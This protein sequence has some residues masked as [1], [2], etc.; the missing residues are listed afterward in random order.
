MIRQTC[1]ELVLVSETDVIF[2]V[3]D[4]KNPS[5]VI[6]LT[7]SR[8]RHYEL[9]IFCHLRRI[10]SKPTQIHNLYRFYL[11]MR[12][13]INNYNESSNEVYLRL[14]AIHDFN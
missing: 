12:N 7:R 13:S 2:V 14:E 10:I 3:H 11:F 9:L 1:F 4:L 8:N 6:A 5:K